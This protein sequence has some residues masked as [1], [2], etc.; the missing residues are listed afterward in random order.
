MLR[1]ICNPL[2]IKVAVF[3]Y[4]AS[5][6]W[7][8]ELRMRGRVSRIYQSHIQQAMRKVVTDA[9]GPISGPRIKSV[10]P[11]QDKTNPIET[12][13]IIQHC[14]WSMIIQDMRLRFQLKHK[15]PI[16][17]CVVKILYVEF[18]RVIFIIPCKISHVIYRKMCILPV[19]SVPISNGDWNMVLRDQY[20]SKI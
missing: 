7:P 15:N 18:Q 20:I 8:R 14:E 12:T 5:E 16:F 2:L 13:G 9:G 6:A 1:F 17:Q 11:D 4:R 10:L 19:P 3:L